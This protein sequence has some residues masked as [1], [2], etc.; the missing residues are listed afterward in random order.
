MDPSTFASY[1]RAVDAGD[2]KTSGRLLDRL[3]REE[4]PLVE[5]CAR[6]LSSKAGD[7]D[8]L[9]QAGAIALVQALRKFDPSRGA[10]SSYAKQWIIP[11]MLRDVVAARPLVQPGPRWTKNPMTKEL[12]RRDHALRAVLGRAPTGA[13]LGVDEAL[14]EAWRARTTTRS[15]TEA[16]EGEK[17]WDQE[18]LSETAT[19]PVE[20]MILP[21]L[22]AAL[23]A[24]DPRAQRIV[25]A[26]LDGKTN[27]EVADEEGLQ[28][29]EWVRTIYQN[30]LSSLRAVLT[31]SATYEV[32]ETHSAPTESSNI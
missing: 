2:N 6:K 16:P 20:E 7:L 12:R 23:E 14:L 9:R 26:I 21:E 24:L 19:A 22:R 32:C 30:S 8:D 10:W 4:I 18:V 28:S 13:E 29:R 15:Y 1:R 25:V 11:A 17:G 27:Q 5:R 3:V 31:K